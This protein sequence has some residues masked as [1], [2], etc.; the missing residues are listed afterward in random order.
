MLVCYYIEASLG[1]Q[2]VKD[3]AAMWETRVQSLSWE[4]LLEKEWQPTLVFLPG[5]SHEQRSLA[6]YSPWGDKCVRHAF[7]TKNNNRFLRQ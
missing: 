2:T 3:L 6:G 7:T 1:T 5:K 4:D